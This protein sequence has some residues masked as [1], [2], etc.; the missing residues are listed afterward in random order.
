MSGKPWSTE[1]LSL[2][3]SLKNNENLTRVEIANRFPNRT[4]DAVFGAL[5]RLRLVNLTHK[6]SQAEVEL[7]TKMAISHVLTRKYDLEVNL[8]AN[9]EEFGYPDIYL[10][11]LNLILE[12]KLREK[13]WRKRHIIEQVRKYEN[14]E[15]TWV[16]CLDK[17]PSW[18]TTNGITWYTPQE[19]FSLLEDRVL[20]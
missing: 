13:M 19:L 7:L 20:G 18:T 12:I 3:E 14:I 11:D 1:E 15:R 16:I 10:P 6:W 17:S 9:L 8:W 2:L 5:K 4:K